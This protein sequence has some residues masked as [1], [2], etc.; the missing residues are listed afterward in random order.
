MDLA[1]GLAVAPLQRETSFH[2]IVVSF[3]SL[4]KVLEFS[5]KVIQWATCEAEGGRL[6]GAWIGV[7]VAGSTSLKVPAWLKCLRTCPKNL[8]IVLSP[9]G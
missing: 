8:T 3:Y 4:S 9:P 2:R 7:W 5:L 1:L 6:G